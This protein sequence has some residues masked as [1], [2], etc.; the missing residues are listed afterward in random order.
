MEDVA[1]LKESNWAC[2][3]CKRV[4]KCKKCKPNHKKKH[5][6]K[7]FNN[8]IDVISYK[9]EGKQAF[10]IDD[11]VIIE[12]Q[13]QYSKESLPKQAKSKAPSNKRKD[14]L[15]KISKTQN[16]E[17]TKLSLIHICRCRRY[18]VCRSRWSPYH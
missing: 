13:L 17:S 14:P 8:L 9:V 1:R 5:K 2:A 7:N 12:K 11:F 15:N 4:C 3:V 18:A 6:S 16:R 10:R